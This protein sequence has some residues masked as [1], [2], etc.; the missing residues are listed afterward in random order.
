MSSRDDFSLKTKDI[1]SK[2]VGT[3]CSNPDCCVLTFGPQ[4]NSEKSINIGVAAHIE[5][6][7]PNSARYNP[8]QSKEERSSINN[9]IWLCQNCAKKIDNDENKYTKELLILW[10]S[11]AEDRAKSA[12]GNKRII[13]E[14]V[15]DT[16]SIV[17]IARQQTT[18][19]PHSVQT[20]RM[21]R[22]EITLRPLR[23]PRN[24]N[25][26]MFPLVFDKA[27]LSPKHSLFN[28]SYQ[29]LGKIIDEKILISVRFNNPCIHSVNTRENKRVEIIEGGGEK[30]S[31]VKFYIPESLPKEKA[32]LQVVAEKGEIPSVDLWTKVTGESDHVYM[33]DVVYKTEK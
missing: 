7:A 24:L 5:G 22:A 32:L 23:M 15:F 20:G 6:A 25:D 9:G 16:K 1:L 14:G 30:S 11:Q 31:F 19:W 10:K 13:A 4:I 27:I 12:I 18:H 26:A 2:R 33:V 21:R 29:N 8:N 3:L 28:I 17:L